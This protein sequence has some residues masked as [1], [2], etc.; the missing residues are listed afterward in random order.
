VPLQECVGIVLSLL[1]KPDARLAD[2]E[3]G[4]EVRGFE[5][6]EGKEVPFSLLKV[7]V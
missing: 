3:L 6:K 4:D 2:G 5:G 1:N 7:C